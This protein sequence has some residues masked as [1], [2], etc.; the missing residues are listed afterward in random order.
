NLELL[1]ELLATLIDSGDLPDVFGRISTIARK[2][3]AHDAAVLMVR[4]PDGVNARIYANSGVDFLPETVPIPE[5][6]LQ[7]PN[8]EHE[9]IDDLTL[10]G[11]RY[12]RVVSMGFRSMVRVA[13]RLEGQFAGTLIFLSKT[14]SAFTQDDVLV[15]RRMADRMTITIARTRENEAL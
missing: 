1:D 3:L 15:A 2:V 11:P 8:W 4:T 9:I 5:E 13:I 6:L 14:L 12:V 10:R 7:N